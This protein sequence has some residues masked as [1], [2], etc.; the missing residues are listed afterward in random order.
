MELRLTCMEAA[1]YWRTDKQRKQFFGYVDAQGKINM[2]NRQYAGLVQKPSQ[3]PEV[4]LPENAAC[5]QPN[6]QQVVA[7]GTIGLVEV[8]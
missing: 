4:V 3:E 7:V 2:S 6:E 1:R 8:Y 5:D